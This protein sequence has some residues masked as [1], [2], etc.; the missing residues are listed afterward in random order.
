MF[1]IF[2]QTAVDTYVGKF[3]ERC[4]KLIT[5]ET[6]MRFSTIFTTFVRQMNS[7]HHRSLNDT[8]KTRAT[9]PAFLLV[10]SAK[11]SV[12][13][14]YQNSRDTCRT[15]RPDGRSQN[16]RYIAQQRCARNIPRTVPFAWSTSQSENT[17]KCEIAMAMCGDTKTQES[18]YK[19]DAIKRSD[20]GK[21]AFRTFDYM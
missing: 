19:I 16:V 1:T 11:A 2:M 7:Q 20:H 15:F 8:S 3:G 9:D 12:L 10:N 21:I 17:D 6:T 13:I 14:W 5:L 4:Q 18:H